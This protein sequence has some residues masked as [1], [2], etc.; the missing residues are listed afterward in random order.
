MIN[1]NKLTKTEKVIFKLN[2]LLFF[3][4]IIILFIISSESKTAEED[5]IVILVSSTNSIYTKGITGFESSFYKKTKI[6]YLSE[7]LEK[8]EEGIEFF[9]EYES[10]QLPFIV[11][12]G[13]EATQLAGKHLKSIPVIHS[14]V[15]SSRV[16]Y[17]GQNKMCGLDL[18]PVLK[19]YYSV[20]KELKPE[21]NK[22][23]SF[24]STAFGEY[25]VKES[26]YEDVF[27]GLYSTSTN[28]NSREEFHRNLENMDED[29][30]GFL[31]VADPIYDKNNFELLSN[32]CK[33]KGIVLMT[34]YPALV[35]IG[36]TFAIV[37]DYTM[38]GEQ[39]ARFATEVFEG[40]VNCKMGPILLPTGQILKFNEDYTLSSGFNISDSFKKR[41]HE[42]ELMTIGIELYYKKLY[43]SSKSAFEKVL[44]ENSGRELAKEYLSLLK[45]RLTKDETGKLTK[46]GD[47][48]FR[49]KQYA[50]AKVAYSRVLKLNPDLKN[51]KQKLENTIV[52]ESE[53]KRQEATLIYKKGNPFLAAKKYLEAIRIL[54]GNSK[55]KGELEAL[56]RKEKPLIQGYYKDALDSYNKRKYGN[57]IQG[58]ENVLIIDPG[59]EKAQEYLRLSKIK[60]DAF[61]RLQRC[62]QEKKSG[63][64][65]LR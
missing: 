13:I 3:F 45:Y 22:I 60:K 10:R 44:E 36:A 4:G 53:E 31:M 41:V 17:N 5:E 64:E 39:T 57:A 6:M 27:H 63:C 29:V 21:A 55:A 9:K 61:E 11:T 56:R 50:Q 20:L 54:P 18:K 2:K 1:L 46:I 35:D 24:Y 34:I 8:S 47:E 38:V 30:D 62:L 19:D 40:R 42:D 51:I 49:K 58:F 33:K 37:P 65:L 48:F 25:S 12:F 59:D 32:Y 23:H 16:L 7:I 14:F 26:E 52:Q 28:V 43:Q 15:Q